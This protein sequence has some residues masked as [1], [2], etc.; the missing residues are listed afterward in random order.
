MVSL[1]KIYYQTLLSLNFSLYFDSD[2]YFEV[3]KIRGFLDYFEEQ[4]YFLV[5]YLKKFVMMKKYI[6]N[7]HDYRVLV[8]TFTYKDS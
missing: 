7:F 2:T 4:N 3:L 6:E 5:D 8:T 1:S